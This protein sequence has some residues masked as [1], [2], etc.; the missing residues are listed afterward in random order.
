MVKQERAQRTRRSLIDA[1]AEVFAQDG[2]EPAR[3]ATISRR[4]GVSNGALHFHFANKQ[5]LA[6]AVEEE[7]VATLVRITRAAQGPESGAGGGRCAVQ[8]LVD[9]TYELMGRLADDIVVRAGFE[10][11]PG[12]VRAWQRWV[13]ETLRR[14]ERDGRLA[15]GVTGR[16]AAHA[17][18]AATVGLEALGRENPE[19][20]TRRRVA[21]IWEVLLPRLAPSVSGTPRNAPPGLRLR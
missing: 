21:G 15:R 14:A 1:A 7:A 5:T 6:Q 4:A 12:P 17:V 2:Y 18:V 8:A 19:W 20:L 9:A 13:E 10:L 11:G 3:L 16:S